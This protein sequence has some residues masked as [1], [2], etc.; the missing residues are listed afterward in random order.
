M[1]HLITIIINESTTIQSSDSYK[2]CVGCSSP[3]LDVQYKSTSK[4]EMQLQSK[5]SK[6]E[7]RK[8]SCTSSE[9]VIDTCGQDNGNGGESVRS[10]SHDKFN[11]FHSEE[12]HYLFGASIRDEWGTT[13][14][15]RRQLFE[16]NKGP[17]K[18][19]EENYPKSPCYFVLPDSTPK[20]KCNCSM[21]SVSNRDRFDSYGNNPSVV[22]EMIA[23][24]SDRYRIATSL[25]IQIQNYCYERVFR[26]D[27]MNGLLLF[28]GK[29]FKAVS[30]KSCEEAAW[31]V[32]G[33]RT[34]WEFDESEECNSR[35]VKDKKEGKKKNQKKRR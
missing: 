7:I 10:T 3:A 15:E 14:E 33:D 21:P 2:H 32:S 4:S 17:A 19:R 26:W 29:F 20:W 8:P 6:K 23:N 16:M 27:S 11:I 18:R 28:F 31:M 30:E 9:R 5:A 35:L 1:Y 24:E 13:K 34:V 22:V 25:D 12:Q